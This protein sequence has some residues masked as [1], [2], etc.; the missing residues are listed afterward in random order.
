[1]NFFSIIFTLTFLLLMATIHANGRFHLR[2]WS[3]TLA[4]MVAANK[5]KDLIKNTERTNV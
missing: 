2:E 3:R 4:H 1:M 5:L